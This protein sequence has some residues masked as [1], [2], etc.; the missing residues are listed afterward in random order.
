MSLSI[1]SSRRRRLRPVLTGVAAGVLALSMAGCGS[2]SDT[3]GADPAPASSSPASAAPTAPRTPTTSPSSSPS[4]SP[5]R[6]PSPSASSSAARPM[7][8]TIKDYAYTGA[9]SVAPGSTVMVTNDDDVAHTVTSDEGD[10]FDVNVAPGAT[11]SFQ[12]PSS[13]GS[14]AYHCTFHSDMHGTLAVS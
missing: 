14:Y 1:S 2:S 12:A 6:S 7:V 5:T 11:E 4:S 8:I 10:D 3:A 9:D 13:P